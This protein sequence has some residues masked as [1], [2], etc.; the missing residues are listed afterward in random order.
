MVIQYPNQSLNVVLHAR[1]INYLGVLSFKNVVF[2]KKKNHLFLLK[3][4]RYDTLFYAYGHWQQNS[5]RVMLR[6]GS[7]HYNSIIYLNGL[8]VTSHEGGH[9]PILADVTSLLRYDAQN[10]LTVAVNNTLNPLTIPQGKVV[11]F[12]NEDLWVHS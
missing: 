2:I 11:Y 9:L 5:M 8:Q 1:N 6:F 4:F 7:I 3:N 10:L 12:H